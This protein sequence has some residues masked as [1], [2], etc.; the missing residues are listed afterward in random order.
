ML[1]DGA[2]VLGML[3]IDIQKYGA[4]YVVSN[5]H[6][7]MSSARGAAILYVSNEHLSSFKPLIISH[8]SGSGFT[9]DFIWDGM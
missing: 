5:C 6:K 8:G 9:S 4:D 2:H 1:L 3:P 7:W